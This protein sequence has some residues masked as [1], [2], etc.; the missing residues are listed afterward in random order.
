MD[1]R[2]WIGLCINWISVASS[3]LSYSVKVLRTYGRLQID[4]PPQTRTALVKKMWAEFERA[5]VEL[6]AVH[7]GTMLTVIAEN[8]HGDFSP[9]VISISLVF[10]L[11]AK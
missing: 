5:G 11:F 2:A 8:G 4:F 10:V 9:E 3:C 1:V 6:N 7:Y